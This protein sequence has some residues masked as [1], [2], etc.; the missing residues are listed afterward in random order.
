LATVELGFECLE[1]LQVSSVLLHVGLTVDA[2]HGTEP[3]QFLLGLLVLLRLTDL[4][5]LEFYFVELLSV[6]FVDVV[7][8]VHDCIFDQKGFGVL[9]VKQNLVDD[10]RAVP[11]DQFV[12]LALDAVLEDAPVAVQ[13]RLLLH[14]FLLEAQLLTELDLVFVHRLLFAVHLGL[15]HPH[16][17]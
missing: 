9:A 11:V 4:V 2:F 17:A 7:F 6:A 13:F 12:D 5:L 16:S 1:F 14:V 15:L 8:D 3:D 10:V